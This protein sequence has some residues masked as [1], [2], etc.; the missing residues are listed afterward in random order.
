[1]KHQSLDFRVGCWI[2]LISFFFTFGC[3]SG[4]DPS[5]SPP[6]PSSS[7]SSSTPTEFISL[8]SG[9]LLAE[10]PFENSEE[11]SVESIV[12]EARLQEDP[13]HPLSFVFV[14]QPGAFSR[15]RVEEIL[16]LSEEEMQQILSQR[17]SSD[18]NSF[19]HQISNR[20]REKV[21]V[22][23][24]DLG[25]GGPG[26]VAVFSREG[27][28]VFVDPARASNPLSEG[29]PSWGADKGAGFDPSVFLF[30]FIFFLIYLLVCIPFLFPRDILQCVWESFQELGLDKWCVQ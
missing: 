15:S 28:T 22:V 19:L 20:L 18:G 3:G 9:V 30:C 6:L 4:L 14:T 1:M 24:K 11:I 12:Q 23:Q 8:D 17:F 21:H 29:L 2:V 5:S 25:E 26:A 7:E 10:L 16:G 27:I 13:L